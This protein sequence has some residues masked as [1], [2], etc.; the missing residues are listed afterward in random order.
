MGNAD[1]P[2]EQIH[3]HCRQEVGRPVKDS[4]VPAQQSHIE[5][6]GD[7]DHGTGQHK[8]AVQ[9]IQLATRRKGRHQPNQN[10]NYCN[11]FSQ[12]GGEH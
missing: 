7:R 9:A 1:A 12:G 3:Q 11:T 2:K 8:A 6:V 10:Q 5:Q 4:R